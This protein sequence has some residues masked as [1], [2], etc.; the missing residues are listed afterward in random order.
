M[1]ACFGKSL[2]QNLENFESMPFLSK[3]VS[4]RAAAKFHHPVEIRNFYITTLLEDDGWKRCT[5]MCQENTAP[6][7]Q[8]DSRPFTSI[9]ANQEICPVLKIGIATI[10]DVRGIE[11][12]VPSLSDPW[13]SLR[14]LISRGK[15]RFVNEI[16]RHNPEIVNDSFLLPMK[17]ENLHNVRFESVK[18]ASGNRGYCSEVSDTAKSND[19]PSSE[20]RKKLQYPRHLLHPREAAILLC[21][22]ITQKKKIPREDRIWDTILGCQKCRDSSIE[23]RISK[24]VTNMVRHHDQYEREEDGAMHWDVIL[25]VLKERFQKQLGKEFTNE[26]WLNCIFLGRFQNEI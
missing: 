16:H 25:P 19:K 13:R 4:L 10:I 8:K 18:L 9:D 5:S 26:E 20:L 14:I 22:Q 2:L 23:T 15:E 11:V 7:N 1:T 6:R 17:E 12:H 21:I 3:I 24:C